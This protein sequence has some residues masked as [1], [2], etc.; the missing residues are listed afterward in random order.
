M[1]RSATLET[2]V[3]SDSISMSPRSYSAEVNDLLKLV[4]KFRLSETPHVE[5]LTRLNLSEPREN[6]RCLPLS[7][8]FSKRL[9]DIVASLSLLIVVSPLLLLT[10]CAVRITSPGSAIYSQ[11]RVGLN[12][13]S[14]KK[15]SDRRRH[16]DTV[17]NDTEER[18]GNGTDRR[19]HLN[20]GL[21]FTIYKFRT[22]RMDAELSGAQFALDNDPRITPV[23]WFL[24]RTRIDELPQLWNIL[25]GDMSLIGPRPE[26][27][28]FMEQLSDEIPGYLDRLGLKP[29]LSGIAQI[30]NGY[31]NEVEG[32]RRK[33]GYDLLYLQNCCLLND[34][35]ILLRTIRVVITGEGA[36]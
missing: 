17:F 12:R 9:F 7:A 33:I 5:W 1:N 10:W 24:R 15:M 14:K 19:E 26:R 22:M 3:S 16:R 11:T 27:P 29:G 25:R 6:I 35:K 4:R 34:L 30:L 36:R 8:R 21:P 20:Y 18:R 23:G 28:E 2:T 32:F 13:R 31:D